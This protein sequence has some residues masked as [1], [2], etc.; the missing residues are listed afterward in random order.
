MSSNIFIQDTNMTTTVYLKKKLFN[1]KR[2]FDIVSSFTGLVLLSPVLL[3]IAVLVK[4]SSKGPVFYRGERA[5]RFNRPFKIYKFRT[6]VPDAEKVGGMSTA[7][8]DPRIT[9]VGH[10]LRRYKLDELPQLI[11][12]LKGDMSIVGPRPEM[13]TYTNLYRG[14]E[15]L[16]LTVRPGITDYAS[17]EFVHLDEVLGSEDADRIY[18]E[19]IRPI[20]NALR[21]KYVKEQSFWGDIKLILTTLGAIDRKG[22][23]TFTNTN[24][25]ASTNEQ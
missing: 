22:C 15:E 18:E 6:M 3:T 20:K 25:V 1:P 21:I 4:L 16:I 12:V 23:G 7:K 14:E 17:I 8:G 24:Y 5:G 9:K 13:P 11:N 19:K 10:I 2:A